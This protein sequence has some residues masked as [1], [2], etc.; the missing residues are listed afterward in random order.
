MNPPKQSINFN[1]E[2][3]TYDK[4]WIKLAAMKDA[5]HLFTRVIFSDLPKDAHILCVGVGTGDELLDMAQHNPNWQFTAVDPSESM[6]NQC[7]QKADKLG[8]TSRCTFHH[9]QLNTLPNKQKFNATTCFLV[10]HHIVDITQRQALF[11]NIATR[12]LPNGLLINADISGDITKPEYKELLNTWLLMYRYA[13]LSKSETKHIKTSLGTRVAIL[14]PIKIEELIKNSGFD[15]T[16]LFFQ[17]L[18][19]HAWY[20][21]MPLSK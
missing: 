11:D 20:S 8:I 18:L 9:G 1:Q 14:P 19:I 2:A 13:G 7:K 6:L 15:Q 16:T 10:A 17:S 21:Q 12:L 5:L 4:K 3:K